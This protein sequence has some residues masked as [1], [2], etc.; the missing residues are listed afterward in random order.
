MKLRKPSSEK[1]REFVRSLETMS[2]D[3]LD[4]LLA[5]YCDPNRYLY[6]IKHL[7]FQPSRSWVMNEQIKRLIHEAL[8]D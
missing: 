6:S 2:S 1:E 4:S 3:E 7:G 8:S 5:T